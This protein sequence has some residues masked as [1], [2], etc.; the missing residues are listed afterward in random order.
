MN[1]YRYVY[2]VKTDFGDEMHDGVVL[3]KNVHKAKKDAA[4]IVENRNGKLISVVRV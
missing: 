1:Y 2:A 4:K 3:N